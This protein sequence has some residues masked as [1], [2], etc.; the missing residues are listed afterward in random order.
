MYRELEGITKRFS[1]ASGTVTVPKGCIILKA[2]CH[3]AGAA[4]MTFPDGIGGT[5]TIPIPT[6]QFFYNADHLLCV[7]QT[8][9]FD[10]VFSGT[11]AYFV[12]IYGERGQF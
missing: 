8:A 10:I 11:D 7:V 12:E 5:I 3:S 4:T 6:T 2:T 9:A 1:G